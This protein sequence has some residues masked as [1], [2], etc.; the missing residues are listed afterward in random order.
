MIL[1]RKLLQLIEAGTLDLILRRWEKGGMLNCQ[2]TGVDTSLVEPLGHGICYMR[3][4]EDLLRYVDR[5]LK[6][7]LFLLSD[8]I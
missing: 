3:L 6:F 1:N 8:E 2:A 4:A 7:I 5:Q